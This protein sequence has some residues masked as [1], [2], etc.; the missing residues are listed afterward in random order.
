MPRFYSDKNV[1]VDFAI[2]RCFPTTQATMREYGI[3]FNFSAALVIKTKESEIR[4]A[5]LN[6][7]SIKQNDS[8]EYYIA[9]NGKPIEWTDQAGVRRSKGYIFPFALLPGNADSEE[10]RKLQ[11]KFMKE[12]LRECQEFVVMARGRAEQPKREY[13]VP[14][15]IAKLATPEKPHPKKDDNLPL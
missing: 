15:E 9:S 12:L 13:D 3:F 6:D 2:T 1:S 10:L 14:E 7:L 11:G 8:G 4:W 5:S